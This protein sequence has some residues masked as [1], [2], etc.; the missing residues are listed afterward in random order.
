MDGTASTH[1]VWTIYKKNSIKLY[2][3]R[4]YSHKS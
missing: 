4:I 1:H 2:G 3:E